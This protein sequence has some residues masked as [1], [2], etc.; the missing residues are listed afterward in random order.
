MRRREFLAAATVTACAGLT[1]AADASPKR[2]LEVRQRET[3]H[4]DLIFQPESP[5]PLRILQITDTHFGSPSA[6]AK[7]R[8]QRSFDLIAAMVKQHQPDFINHTGDFVNNDQGPRVSYEAIEF[9]DGL[10]VPWAHSL[11]NHDIGAVSTEDYRQRLKQATFGYFDADDHREYS[12]R[13]DVTPPGAER[14]AWTIYCFDSGSRAGSKHVSRRQLDWY[15]RQLE[16][17]REREIACPAVAMIH[18]PVVEFHKLQDAHSF[19][20]IFGERVCFESDQGGTFTKLK[21]AQR[22]RAI[23]SGHDHQNDY[24]G[25]WEGVELVYGRV[26]GW[27]GYGDLERGGRL[28]ELDPATG[29]YRHRIVFATT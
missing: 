29:S 13:L 24:C 15:G 9:M 7:E 17:D 8:D 1:R 23:F 4:F 5:R 10:G 3:D 14:P 28:I 12:Y 26:T 22:V 16:R 18:I 2:A 20:G 21:N 11:G 19:R 6:K 27:S 25:D